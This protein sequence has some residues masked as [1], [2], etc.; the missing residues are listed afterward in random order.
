MFRKIWR[1]LIDGWTCHVKLDIDVP[2]SRVDGVPEMVADEIKLG[3]AKRLGMA[4]DNS[5]LVPTLNRGRQTWI[6]K[7]LKAK[8]GIEV[9]RETVRCWF[10]GL[11]YPRPDKMVALAELLQVDEGWLSHG[12]AA[13]EVF[14]P[15][16]VGSSAVDGMVS[17]L[18]GMLTL[19][20]A[21][22]A[23]P[24]AYDERRSSL[25][26]YAIMGGRQFGVWAS[27]A[28][29]TDSGF[30]FTASS[31][32]SGV[33]SL[34]V[35]RQSATAFG[36][37]YLAPHIVKHGVLQARHIEL[38]ADE[39]LSVNGEALSEITDFCQLAKRQ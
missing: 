32:A 37:Y 39:K 22:C 1:R 26:F 33:I 30:R 8:F 31:K 2:S 10:S 16:R 28:E 36:V 3:F 34:G 13:E 11:S 18:I 15:S 35:I 25:H 14:S 21:S 7:E 4:C 12:S 24:E 17:L 5:D 27:L 20:G 29:K 23:L 9:S 6:A 19:S 38:L